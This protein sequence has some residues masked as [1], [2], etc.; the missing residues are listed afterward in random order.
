[1]YKLLLTFRYLRRKL[2][3]IFAVLAVC[4]C[5]AMVIIVSSIMGGFLDL[6]RTAGKT[7]MGDVSIYPGGLTGFGHYEQIISEISKLPEV[8]AASP[9]IVA[10]GLLK[11]PGDVIKG[12]QVYGVNGPQHAATTGFGNTIYW[13]PQRIEPFDS[14]KAAY[15]GHD[16]VKAALDLQPPWPGA[17]P[18]IVPGIEVSPYNVRLSDGSYRH[19]PP[20]LATR[21]TLTILPVTSRGGVL[22]PATDQFAVVNEFNSGLFDADSSHVFI[23][24]ATA[25]KMMAMEATARIARG[26]D[27]QLILNP[28]GTPKIVGQVPARAT[29]IHVKAA[30]GV[31]ANQLQAAIRPVYDRLAAQHDDLPPFMRVAT[32]EE[33]QATFLAAVENERGLVTVL[34]SI[35]SIVAVVMVGVIFYMIVLEKTRDIGILRSIGASPA[36]VASIFLSFGAV[37]GTLGALMGSTLAYLIVTYINEI[38]TWLGQGLGE[39]TLVLGLPLTLA[40]A[41]ML[42]AWVHQVASAIFDTRGLG[43]VGRVAAV[44][45]VLGLAGGALAWLM[46]GSS[47][48]DAAIMLAI[49]ALGGAIVFVLFD[50]PYLAIAGRSWSPAFKRW[51]VAALGLILGIVTVAIAYASVEDLSDRLNT[52]IGFQIWDKSVYFF[53]RIPSR[54]DWSEIGIVVVVAI[55]ASIVG[56][57]IPG[58]RAAL[59]DP[60]ES[61]RYE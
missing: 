10:Y 22:E 15:A 27:G 23:P 34:F 42:L 14:L 8:E 60:I 59:V 58:V 54:V 38:H 46:A 24:F 25:Q 29:E 26:P 56:T 2:I 3:P 21:L 19:V 51:S 43:T 35:I 17:G 55:V 4:L 16:P 49:G 7:L 18:A 47:L 57:L 11:L 6:V 37:V 31:S 32:W 48:A 36:G 52:A 40:I 53:D 33:R 41:M 45:L 13:T 1:M 44:G 30:P 28:D 50:L 20:I 9:V 61:L 5:T 12:V 39:A